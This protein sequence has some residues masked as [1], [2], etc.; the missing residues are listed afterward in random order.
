MGKSIEERLAAVEQENASLRKRIARQ[1]AAWLFS[2][3]A[4]VGGVAVISIDAEV[5]A[6]RLSVTVQVAT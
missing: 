2:V 4:L 1:N 5:L 3:L 6:P